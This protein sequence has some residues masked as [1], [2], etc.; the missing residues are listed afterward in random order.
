MSLPPSNTQLVADGRTT[1][2]LGSVLPKTAEVRNGHLFIGGVDMVQLAREQGTALYVFDEADL[3]DR[4]VRYRDA[5]KRE[6]QD[7]DV[8]Y[9]SKAFLNKAVLQLVGQEGLH[10][11]VSG[12]G[13]L[14]IAQ[15]AG[16][17]M[18]RV[19][20]HGN[21]KT[22]RELA[23]ALD[24]GVGRIVLDSRIELER[25]NRLAGERGMVQ[26]VFMRITPGVEADTHEYIRTGCEDSKFG[27]TMREDFAFN[28]VGDV[29]AAPNV[30]LV[31]LHCHIG[32][33]IFALHSFDEAVAVMVDFIA[34][35]KERYGLEIAELDMGGGLGIAYLAGD[36]PSSIEDF[37]A[38]V[39]GSVARHCDELGVKRPHLYVEPG[40]SLVANA[41]V[42][43]YT[44]GILKTLPGIRKYV[45]VDGGM[46]DNIRTALYHADYEAVI[47]NKADQPRTEI[48]TLCG[49]H[50]ESGDAVVLDGS[51][52]HPDLGD[53]ACVF[54]TG[55]YCSTMASNYNGQPR[56]AV[57]FVKDGAARV[58]TR[59]ETYADLL[60]RDL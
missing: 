60:A 49:K 6:Y 26:D 30:R 20:V 18:E 4:M 28:C 13:E 54:G 34:R 51:I 10:L 33:Q 38:S 56:P 37:A 57:V 32:S 3:L 27:F 50:C 44:V 52:Q 7:A 48:A 46:S 43:L 17:P 31:G 21:N 8:L 9:A 5:F 11:D 47:A 35:I 36:K 25:V 23:E 42:T 1:M 2:E 55:A 22:E 16:F 12:G 45:A 19:F 39:C 24:A 41:G 14:A 53:I 15:A 29:L 59:R 40:R 58:V